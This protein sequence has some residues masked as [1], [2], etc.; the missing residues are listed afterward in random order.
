MKKSE[1]KIGKLYS[2]GKGRI[3]KVVD[4]G[5]QYKLYDAQVCEDNL[6][7]EIVNDGSKKNRTAGEQGNMTLAAF[8]SW[9]KEEVVAQS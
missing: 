8:A 1:I 7:Y 5:P 2:N 3:R 4:M 6:R 9:A